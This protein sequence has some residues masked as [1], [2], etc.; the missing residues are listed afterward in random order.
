VSPLEPYQVV[1]YHGYGTATRALVLGRVLQDEGI[2]PA[3]PTHGLWRNLVS[4]YQRIESDPLPGARVQLRLAGVER[5]LVADDE[6]FLH[7]W[8]DVPA[9]LEPGAWHPVELELTGVARAR[10][11]VTMSR[12]LVPPETASFGIISDLDDTV[13]QSDVRNLVRAARLMLLE[14]ARTRLPFPGVAAF[15]RALEHG[16]SGSRAG[17]P[18]F[19]VSSSPWN[20]YDV[21]REFL[22]RQGIPTGPLLLRDWDFG[23]ALLRTAGHKMRVIREILD[24]YPSL[25][26]VLIG[27]SGQ[28]DP[29]IYSEIVRRQPGR[30]LAIYIRNVSPRPERD[31]SIRDLAVTVAH[32]GSTLVLADDT[33]AAARHAAAHGWIANA[34]LA[35]IGE[36][37]GADEGAQPGK[38]AVPG[39][40]APRSPT[41]VVDPEVDIRDVERSDAGRAR[42]GDATG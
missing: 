28:E 26:F 31:A 32:V 4:M 36:E 34:A 7:A 5:E 37:K 19:Y 16:A 23:R 29:E 40:E 38:A 10:G 3:E 41:V 14:N 8:V 17:N 30:I 24:A 35:E 18:I 20:V 13:L 12:V 27:D 33:L 15:Y 9:P 22:D 1:G 42:R 25:P 11:G 21:L 6:G 39:Q 2:A